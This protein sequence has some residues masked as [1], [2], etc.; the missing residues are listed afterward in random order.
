V[1][2]AVLISGLLSLIVDSCL[3]DGRTQAKSGTP[4]QTGRGIGSWATGIPGG[5]AHRPAQWVFSSHLS[6]SGGRPGDTSSHKSLKASPMT[7]PRSKI[8]TSLSLPD[9]STVEEN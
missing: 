9:E 4:C 2:I 5:T 8:V 1:I 3:V 7:S 6:P